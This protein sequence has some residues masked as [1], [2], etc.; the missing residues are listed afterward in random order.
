MFKELHL[1][2]VISVVLFLLIYLIKTILLLINKN[3]ALD[4]FKKITKVPEMIVSVTFLATGIY[5]MTQIPEIKSF[6]IIKLVAVALSIPIAIIGFKKNSKVLASVAMLLI[7]G[8]YGLAEMSKKQGMH[9]MTDT[10][11]AP[12]EPVIKA[13]SDTSKVEEADAAKTAEFNALRAKKLYAD[14]CVSCHGADGK[15][16]KAGAKDLTLSKMDAMEAKGIVTRGKGTMP[17]VGEVLPSGEIN[18][19]VN[20]IQSFKE[21]K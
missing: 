5:L 4:K 6:L 9:K 14:Y 7:I 16:Q 3:E 17:G 10:M 11:A 13:S 12:A 15:A 20:Y 2:H 21:K 1:T 18:A 8:A 19:V